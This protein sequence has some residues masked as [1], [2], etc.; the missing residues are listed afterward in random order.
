[1]WPLSATIRQA[2]RRMISATTIESSGSIG[3]Q[4]VV[5]ITIDAITAATEPSR[6]PKTCSTAA[7]MLRLCSSPVRR[8]RNAIT[9]TARPAAAIPEHEPAQD[10]NG[11][12]D[13]PR[14]LE[15]DPGR[16]R[17]Q[18]DAV[19]E[20]DEHREAVEAVGAPP[21]GR[22]A[23]EPEAEPR[24]REAREVGQHVARVGEQRE[25]AREHAADDLGDHEPP[26][27]SA[28]SATLRSFA[29]AIAMMVVVIVGVRVVLDAWLDLARAGIL[30]RELRDDLRAKF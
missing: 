16:D 12:V 18:R 25:G 24:E 26:V 7:R 2:E 22:L 13:P 5:R 30:A 1:M 8:I 19:D 3:I 21:I 4:P 9:L 29:R 6:S 23:R 10:L 11:L 17:E 15:H 28:A 14:G 27:R 20:R